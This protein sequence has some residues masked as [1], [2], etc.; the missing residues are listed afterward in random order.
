MPR[1]RLL[2]F[3]GLTL[4]C[5]AAARSFALAEQEE[6]TGPPESSQETSEAQETTPAPPQEQ[7]PPPDFEE[8]FEPLPD[9]WEIPYPDSPRTVKG[10]LRDPYNQNILKGDRPIIGNSIFF[11]F[12]A[13]L[14]T[15]FEGR[16]LPVA[17]G[18]SADDPDSL[19]FF[20]SGRQLFTSPKAILSA[21]LFKGQTAFRPKDWAVKVT[22]V[23]N[24]NYLRVQEN[25]L[26]NIDVREGITRRRNDFGLE[27]AFGEVKLA[28]LSHQFDTLSLRAGIQPFVSD[29]RGLIFS[30]FNLGARLFGNA[31]SNRW[32]YNLAFFDLLEKETNSELNTFERRE[33]Q[34][35][36]ANLFR[37]DFFA[38]GYT[39]SASI[40]HSREEASIHYDSNG[41]L[42]RPAKIGTV[43]PHEIKATYLGISGDGHIGRLNL[44]HAFY[45]V[46]GEDERHPLAN[47]KVDIRAEMAALELSVD[48]DWMRFKGSFFF[49]SGDGDPL[50][51]KARGFDSIY[52]STNFAGGPFSFWNR[53]A[54]AL[55][56]TGVLLKGPFTLLPD[57]RSNKFEGQASFVNPG[58]MLFNLG[59][60]ADLT[61]KLR[62]ILNANYL[63][64][65]KTESLER[66]L[67]QP[68]IRKAIGL[69]L[70]G[71]ILYR[72]LLNE[73]IVIL[74][75]LTG[76]FSGAGFDDIYTS[77]CD[78]PGCGTESRTLANA[79]CVVKL[80][81]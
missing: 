59:Y 69:D 11:V 2:W 31:S 45:W 76:L 51:E 70:G 55:T 5:W 16:V 15:P 75:G 46:F 4:F 52:D 43:R 54:I 40:H 29:F 78:V 24:L 23:F 32:Q 47:R 18:V 56:Q 68:G 27:E 67:F 50:D 77:E 22:P 14:E 19:G 3:A 62:A 64:F 73:N 34:V 36:I 48:R 9:R 71:G 28:D 26:V 13:T 49:A 10:R 6:P 74:A 8:G 44:S 63:F 58:L 35:W 1:K 57:L 81:Y 39:I 7:P 65:H 79:F 12:T 41:F 72:P 66:L 53:S 61:P 25:S 37:Q 33:Q 80:T 30:D 38:R 20:G 42:V 21:E 17:S 60:D